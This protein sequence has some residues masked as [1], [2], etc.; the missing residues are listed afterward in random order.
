MKGKDKEAIVNKLIAIFRENGPPERMH[1]DN[2]GEF[3]NF[4]M[5]E[6]KE[7]MDNIPHSKG[8]PRNP[9]C[10]GLIERANA[11]C[12]R[13]I[14][15]K[16]IQHG[17]AKRGEDFPWTQ[18]LDGVID[19]ENGTVTKLYGLTPFFCLRWKPHNT[20]HCVQLDPEEIKELHRFMTMR[21]L[22][23][24]DTYD[25]ALRVH[26]NVGDEVNVRANHNSIGKKH[27]AIGPWTARAFIHE[28]LSTTRRDYYFLRWI[29]Q[30]LANEAPGSISKRAYHCSRLKPAMSTN[31][32]RA[33]AYHD[34]EQDILDDIDLDDAT[35][36]EVETIATEW[37][38]V[39]AIWFGKPWAVATYPTD[40]RRRHFAGIITG[41]STTGN[42]YIFQQDGDSHYMSAN[43]K[44]EYHKAWIQHGRPEAYTYTINSKGHVVVNRDMDL[45]GSEVEWQTCG[46]EDST[47]NIEGT[48]RTKN[49]KPGHTSGRS[50][51]VLSSD[52]GNPKTT[53]G[54]SGSP[55]SGHV[56]ES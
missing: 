37:V 19:G 9:R 36:N 16:C 46:P 4:L 48:L 31:D 15:Q 27:N 56:Y 54:D 18:Y 41:R 32:G 55:S 51:L 14:I 42:G 22:K 11:T 6:L 44:I 35:S 13:K 3:D 28:D 49:H 47:S 45:E 39:P 23:Q 40:W 8:M 12:K 33:D 53:N 25:K 38:S 30:G 2:G 7:R 50:Q 29:T 1:S 43:A 24:A 10:Q 21:Q 17:Y 5:T 20:P 34:L 26:Y 52:S